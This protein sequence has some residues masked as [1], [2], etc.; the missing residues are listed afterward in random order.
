[1]KIRRKARRYPII[2]VSAM[3]DIAF[4]LLI[5]IMLVSII[6]Y[7]KEIKIDYAISKNQQRTQADKNFEI[8]V[9]KDGVV[10]YDGNNINLQE[11]QKFIE[12]KYFE[13][14]DVRFHVIADKSTKYRY[15]NSVVEL[16][17]QT[18]VNSVSLVVKEKK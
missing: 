12:K 3:S 2:P 17:K 4:L 6:N 16:L 11:L 15:V 18:Q 9:N 7:R 1:M 5:F 10:F 14:P 13:T 8:W